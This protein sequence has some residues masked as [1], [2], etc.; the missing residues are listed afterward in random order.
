MEINDIDLNNPKQK[1]WFISDLHFSHKAVMNFH[2]K[3]R[4]FK[5]IEQ[6]NASLID[7]WNSCVGNEDLVFNLGDFCFGDEEQ[8]IKIA[9]RLNGKHILIYGNHD[10]KIKRSNLDCFFAKFDYLNLNISRNGEKYNFALFHYPIFEWDKMHYGSFHLYG[11]V[12]NADLTSYISERS[13]NVCY[14]NLGRMISLQEVI[15]ML[16]N[17]PIKPCVH[18][19]FLQMEE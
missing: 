9:K 10:N 13:L 18:N 15:S 5:S 19:G 7:M 17:K 14:D 8:I 1:I 4:N 16:K 11:H 6:M 3:F 2:P 12:H